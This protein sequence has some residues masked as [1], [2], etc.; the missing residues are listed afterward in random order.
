MNDPSE[1]ATP[2]TAA[3]ETATT[4]APSALASTLPPRSPFAPISADEIAAFA[5][6]LAQSGAT[7]PPAQQALLGVIVDKARAITPGD[8]R[9]QE[10]RLGFADA[11]QAVA[12]AQAQAYAGEDPQGWARIDPIWVKAGFNDTGSVIEVTAKIVTGSGPAT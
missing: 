11:L 4:P 3:P 12:L 7:L 5:D 8:V 9:A 6:K 10:L 1:T 2:E